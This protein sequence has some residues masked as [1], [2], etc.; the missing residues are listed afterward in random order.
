MVTKKQVERI[1]NKLD[2]GGNFKNYYVFI[3]D[4]EGD[5]FKCDKSGEEMELTE[6]E[7]IE[8]TNKPE[9]E[10]VLLIRGENPKDGYS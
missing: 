5:I 9:N 2:P 3:E 10:V 8:F 6:Q 1:K 4:A 7:F